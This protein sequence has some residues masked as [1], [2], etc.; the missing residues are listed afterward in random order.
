MRQ[1]I[2]LIIENKIK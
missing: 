1:V 2:F